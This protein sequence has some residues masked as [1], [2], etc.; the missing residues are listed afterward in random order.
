[1]TCPP[2]R[3]KKKKKR[4]SKNRGKLQYLYKMALPNKNS[5]EEPPDVLFAMHG[6]V[7]ALLGG[8]KPD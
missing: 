1:M 6:G 5:G 8:H 3:V 4:Y 7:P 2:P